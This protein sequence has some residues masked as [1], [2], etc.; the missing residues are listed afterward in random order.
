MY[1]IVVMINVGIF[2]L[3][4]LSLNIITGYAGQPNIGQGAFFGIGAYTGAVL[5][6]KFGIY[7]W[8]AMPFAAIITGFIGFFLGLISIRIKE[9]FLAIVTIALNFIVAAV[10]QNVEFFGAA[11]G[12]SVPPPNWFG[13]PLSYQGYLTI[14]IILIILVVIF[15]KWIEKSWLGMALGAIRNNEMA[16]DSLGIDTKK[17]K[18]MAFVIGTSIAGLTG[19]VY[20]HYM[21]F[22]MASD[23]GFLTSVTILSMVILGGNN[24]IRG[25]IIG[26]VILGLIPEVFRFISD[27]RLLVYA[28]ILILMIRFQPSGLLGDDSFVWNKLKLLKASLGRRRGA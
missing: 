1:A 24:T 13:E 7:F 25:P 2:V 3:L 23:F 19:V 15:S 17:F 6:G 27:Y 4:A 10:F 21:T 8:L 22:I 11:M 20:A 26:A 16:A 5:T 12:L 28:G 18:I 14:V 9:D